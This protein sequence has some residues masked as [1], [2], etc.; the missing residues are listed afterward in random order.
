MTGRRHNDGGV[1]HLFRRGGD[2][3]GTRRRGVVAAAAAAAARRQRL[4]VWKRRQTGL[5]SG[6]VAAA[7][8]P[9]GV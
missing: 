2:R 6:H 3:P 1:R 9:T 5:K 4:L 7:I 8:N